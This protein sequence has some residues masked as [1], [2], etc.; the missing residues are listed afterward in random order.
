MKKLYILLSLSVLM[1]ACAGMDQQYQPVNATGYGIAAPPPLQFAAP[2][3]LYVVPSGASYVYM[4]PNYD[5]VYFYGGNWYRFYNGYWFQSNS[6]NG[7]WGYIE[8]SMVPQVIVVVPPEYVHY[9]PYG[10]YRIHYDDFYSNWRTWDHKRHWDHYDWYNHERRD[11]VRRERYNRIETERQ[12]RGDQKP[13]QHDGQR[14]TTPRPEP[15]HPPGVQPTTP[16]PAPTQPPW[17]KP[18]TG[19]T[20]PPM[21]QPAPNP[22]TTHPPSVQQAPKPA[23][24]QQGHPQHDVQKKQ[25]QQ[26]EKE[27]QK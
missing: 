17:V 23:P 14:P 2:P 26:G 7:Y 13:R 9:V 6:Y 1:S 11:D 4:V 10:Y 8:P 21:V 27:D 19:P 16:K 18:P 3:D 24:T 20:H 22:V 12:H 25:H 5:G 15:T